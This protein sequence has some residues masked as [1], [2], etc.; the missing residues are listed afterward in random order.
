M[1]MWHLLR[2]VLDKEEVNARLQ[3]NINNCLEL[4]NDANVILSGPFGP[5]IT[6]VPSQN[7]KLVRTPSMPDITIMLEDARVRKVIDKMVVYVLDGGCAFEQLIKWLLASRPCYFMSYFSGMEDNVLEETEPDNE[8]VTECQTYKQGYVPPPSMALRSRVT[9]PPCMRNPYIKDASDNG[10]DPF[11]D[12]RAKCTGDRYLVSGVVSLCSPFNVALTDEDMNKGFNKV[13]SKGLETSL[14]KVLRRQTYE[15][16]QFIIR[17]AALFEEVYIPIL[18]L[19]LIQVLRNHLQSLNVHIARELLKYAVQLVTNDNLDFGCASIIEAA[20]HEM[21]Y[22][23]KLCILNLVAYPIPNNGF[24]RYRAP[25]V[26]LQYLSYT[27][28]ID[29]WA[30]GAILAELFTLCPLFLGERQIQNVK[31]SDGTNRK[32]EHRRYFTLKFDFQKRREKQEQNHEI[33]KANHE[34]NREKTDTRTPKYTEHRQIQRRTQRQRKRDKRRKERWGSKKSRTGR[35]ARKQTKTNKRDKRN[36]GGEKEENHTKRT[37]RRQSNRGQT[38][39]E[40][41]SGRAH[42]RGRE[43]EHIDKEEKKKRTQK[44][45]CTQSAGQGRRPKTQDNTPNTSRHRTTERKKNQKQLNKQAR[46][47]NHQTS[48][49]K[50]NR[51]KYTQNP[52]GDQRQRE[53]QASQRGRKIGKTTTGNERA[54]KKQRSPRTDAPTRK[55]EKTV[56]IHKTNDETAVTDERT[57]PPTPQA[58][59]A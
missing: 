32:M 51:R 48:E 4:C 31:L 15:I 23:Q 42:T 47:Y 44:K 58:H 45:K 24:T 50:R 9:P 43:K 21:V 49:E 37:V 6:S 13:Y 52:G 41:H 28:A 3:L 16:K 36:K 27:P 17:H 20:T 5:P 7:S 25:E 38:D 35:G 2:F 11:G 8:P 14:F 53:A 33:V 1:G 19:S 40:S 54:Q 29:M 12:R 22:Y 59:G 30:V 34:R 46:N 55:E 39:T 56:K 10:V 57:H 26:L 18:P